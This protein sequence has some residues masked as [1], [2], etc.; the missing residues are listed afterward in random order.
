MRTIPASVTRLKYLRPAFINLLGNIL[1]NANL[2][3]PNDL[4]G[5]W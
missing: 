5:L 1:E 3:L 4:A 2:A